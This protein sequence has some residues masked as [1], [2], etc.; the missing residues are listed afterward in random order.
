MNDDQIFTDDLVAA[1]VD[2]QV[3]HWTIHPFSA[4]GNISSEKISKKLSRYTK[5]LVPYL[6]LIDK[7]DLISRIFSA[8]KLRFIDY[9]NYIDG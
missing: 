1:A 3:R 9:T 2:S 7:K 8:A 5:N 6:Y 4:K